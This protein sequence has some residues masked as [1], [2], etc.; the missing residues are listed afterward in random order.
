MTSAYGF[1]HQTCPTIVL[2]TLTLVLQSA[3]VAAL[4][5][6]AR[7]HHQGYS[8][9]RPMAFRYAR[10]ATHG[11]DCLLAHAGDSVGVV[12]SPV[13]LFNPGNLLFTFPRRVILPSAM[14]IFFSRGRGASRVR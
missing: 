9:A 3:G 12:L 1:V 11:I 2:G 14:E 7:A 6:W 10:G 13:L 5:E 4:I 8:P